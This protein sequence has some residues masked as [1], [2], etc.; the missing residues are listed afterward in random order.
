MKTR[1]RAKTTHF[2][3][4]QP[5]ELPTNRLPLKSDVVNFYRKESRRLRLKNV[6]TT[7]WHVANEVSKHVHALWKQK[8]NLPVLSISAVTMKV[9]T[10]LQE[11]RRISK[12]PE[13][14]RKA[15]QKK[16]DGGVVRRLSLPVQVSGKL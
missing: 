3:L 14:R 11:V 12:V 7:R 6:K 8:G 5:G 9:L 1:S 10:L 16:T 15:I 13:Q 4:G 2:V